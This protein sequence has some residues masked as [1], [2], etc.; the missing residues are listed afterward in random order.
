M[1][2]FLL[3]SIMG[4][5]FFGAA[6]GAALSMLTLMGRSNRKMKPALL[7]ILH[8][9]NGTIFFL[10]LL[11]ISYLCIKY[12]AAA[13]DR[14]DPRAI[15]HS[16]LA[17]FLLIIFFTKMLI[18]RFFKQLLKFAPVLGIIVLSLAF[19]VTATSAGFYFLRAANP[20]STNMDD[21]ILSAESID[22]S[23]E[24]G[25]ILF[26]KKCNSCHYADKEETLLGP[27]LEG[28]L[29]KEKLP[30]SGRSATIENVRDQLINPVS[31]MP[32]FKDLPEQDI[33]DLLAYMKI[34]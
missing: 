7:K 29:N 27:G 21:S 30:H 13:G 1:P 5:I 18:V 15:S 22:G 31:F 12:V 16:V 14:L 2:I 4:L 8:K 34:I 25:E 17:L 10:L 23:A 32:S 26:Q 19:V 24:K 3:K 20:Y 9:T 33:K 28:L 11:V 6:L